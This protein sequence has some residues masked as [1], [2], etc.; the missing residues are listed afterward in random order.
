MFSSS[1]LAAVFG[2]MVLECKTK[3]F[4]VRRFFINSLPQPLVF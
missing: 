4:G 1:G 3:L 2:L